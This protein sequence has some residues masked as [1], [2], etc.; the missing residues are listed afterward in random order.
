MTRAPLCHRLLDRL[1]RQRQIARQPSV[2]RLHQRRPAAARGDSYDP[3]TDRLGV[4]LEHPPSFHFLLVLG[5]LMAADDQVRAFR[6][7][8][9]QD[10]HI[11]LDGEVGQRHDEIRSLVAQLATESS[12]I[13]KRIA[14]FDHV[15]RSGYARRQTEETD[16]DSVRL[17]D[18]PLA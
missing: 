8:S 13:L 12:G 10:G 1:V 15:V 4:R 2:L 9:L 14:D 3:R 17:D 18:L 6:L 5:V 16:L 7:E 11:L